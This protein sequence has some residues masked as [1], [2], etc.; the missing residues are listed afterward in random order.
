MWDVMFASN[1]SSH[2]PFRACE[3]APHAIG[4]DSICRLLE[5]AFQSPEN[6]QVWAYSCKPVLL[7]KGYFLMWICHSPAP[8]V[9][10]KVIK[11]TGALNLRQDLFFY[12][13]KCA[14]CVSTYRLVAK[15]LLGRSHRPSP[16]KW[17]NTSNRSTPVQTQETTSK[18]LHHMSNIHTKI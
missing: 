1:I 7:R 2:M 11:V 18:L 14:I 5:H 4:A 8:A 16:S 6:V 10:H 9:V 17:G 12:G 15:M 3:A 13:L